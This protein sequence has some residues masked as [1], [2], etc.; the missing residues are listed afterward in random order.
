HPGRRQI[1]ACLVGRHGTSEQ[2][3]QVRKLLAEADPLLRLRAAQGLLAGR[4]KDALPTL[5][6]LLVD[7]PR[8]VA[9]Q[10]EELLCYAAGPDSPP[11]LIRDGDAG[12]RAA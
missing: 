1:A 7:T 9:W 3:E 4:Q 10:A 12:Q 11:M 8:D 2:R 5:I 6:D